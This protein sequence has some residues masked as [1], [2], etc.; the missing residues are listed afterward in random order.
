VDPRQGLRRPLIQATLDGTI[1]EHLISYLAVLVKLCDKPID[2]ARIISL[3]L[4]ASTPIDFAVRDSLLPASCIIAL[5]VHD[6]NLF[7]FLYVAHSMC[8]NV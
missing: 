1:S 8:N 3:F 7:Y 4:D 6:Y 2:C 5:S